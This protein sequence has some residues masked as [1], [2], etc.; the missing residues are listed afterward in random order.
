MCDEKAVSLEQIEEVFMKQDAV[1]FAQ[2]CA[3]DV[4]HGPAWPRC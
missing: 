4:S 1:A 2:V 3:T